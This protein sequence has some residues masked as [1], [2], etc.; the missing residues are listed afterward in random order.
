MFDPTIG[1]HQ[2]VAKHIADF[3]ATFARFDSS[4]ASTPHAPPLSLGAGTGRL[5]VHELLA[6]LR[7]LGSEGSPVWNPS[8]LELYRM[9][10]SVGLDLEAQ[11]TDLP[12][13]VAVLLGPRAAICRQMSLR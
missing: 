11:G 2:K 10:R 5:G 6:L 8:E 3:Q 12:G 7:E 1:T 4:G 13:L 9:A